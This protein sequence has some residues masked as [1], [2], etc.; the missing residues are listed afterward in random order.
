MIYFG[1]DVPKAIVD[2][3]AVD[4]AVT[5]PAEVCTRVTD[6]NVNL[7][8]THTYIG[9]LVVRLRH[10]ESGRSAVLFDRPC[11]EA[12]FIRAVLDDAAVTALQCPP[13]GTYRPKELLSIFNGIDG[14]G[15]WS[16]NVSDHADKDVGTLDN[17]GLNLKCAT[18][19]ASSQIGIFDHGTW[20]LDSNQSWAWEGTPSDTLGEF[21]AG[22]EGAIPVAGDWDG[23]GITKMGIFKDGTW[24][25]DINGNYQ[26]DGEP[27]DRLGVFGTGLNG[28]IPVA[29]DWNGN[30]IT[31]I[32]VYMNGLWYLDLNNNYQWDGEPTD[33]MGVF[34][35]GL[36]GEV[37][38]A[39]DWNGDRI[40]EIGV[41]M[42]GIWYLDKNRS[43]TWD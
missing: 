5:V 11:G 30:G 9:D 2:T 22:L 23:D 26:W 34:G 13:N 20:Y 4:S 32:G 36:T 15:T 18:P 40:S 17:W 27:A 16:L 39:G 37:P 35:I 33:Q 38:V 1:P 43:W 12:P 25:L 24:Y 28:A 41:Y 8:I 31:K 19:F 29:G 7:R 6:V 21:G 14:S 3:A 42:D 10:N